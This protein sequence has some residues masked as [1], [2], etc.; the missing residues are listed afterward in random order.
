MSHEGKLSLKTKIGYGAGEMSSAIFWSTIAFWLMNFL[1]DEVGLSAAL[2]GV[3]IMLGKA[4]DAF[5]DPGVGYLS[6]MTRTR[7]GRRRPWFL[8]A[9]LPFGAAYL[10]MFTNFHISGQTQM[11]I[12]SSVAFIF[13][14]LAY[15]CANVPYNALLPEL[16]SDY[17]ERTSLTGFKSAYAAVGSLIGAGAAMPIISHF[18]SRT[19]GFIAMGIVFGVLIIISVLTPFFTVKEPVRNA[20]PVPHNILRSNLDAF[21]NRPFL[22]ILLTW[23]LNTCAI[24]VVTATMIYYFKYIFHNADLITPASLIMLL[25]S[26]AFIPIAVKLS[27]KIGKR[28]TYLLGMS[29][30]TVACLLIFFVG[31]R[32]GIYSVY[33][34]MFI[35]GTGLSTHSVI[36]WSIVPD[37]IEYD[38]AQSGVRREGVY[39]GLWTFMIKIGQ[40]LAI[41]F[42]G[43]FLGLFGY[44]PDIPQTALSLLGIKLLLG[45]IS[46]FFF[47]LALICLYMYPIDKKQY[48]EIQEKIK[49][50]EAAK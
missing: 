49:K 34:L 31:E 24:T 47:I 35:A 1:T 45:P 37:T 30:V 3:A 39:Y 12:W 44:V 9:A 22:M 32:F 11:F 2:A 21:K 17:N 41:L 29:T 4:L 8:F 6:D 28:N 43:V 50:M 10:L 18:K 36:P 27:R 7:M 15:S 33:L 26:L 42:V 23:T 19:N 5:I 46:A 25:T 40:A 14:S 13:L 20:K 38:Y 48:D 16:T